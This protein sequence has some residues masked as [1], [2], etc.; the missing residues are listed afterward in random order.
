MVKYTKPPL[1]INQQIDLLISRGMEISDRQTAEKYLSHI[2][3]YRLRAYW[4]PFEE[5]SGNEAHQFRPGTKFEHALSLYIFDRKFRLL[6]LEAIERVEVSLRTRFS[7]I[8]SLKYGCHAYLKPEYFRKKEKHEELLGSLSEEIERSRETFI[9]HYKSKYTD[10]PMPPIWATCEVMSLGQL[11]IWFE[12]LKKR[13]DRK[14]IAEIY[15]LDEKVICSFMHHLSH[16]RNLAAHHSRLW[17]RQMTIT[18]IIPSNPQDVSRYFN[19]D[20]DRKIYNT[21]AMLVY[22]LN[23]ISPG[24]TWP[25]RLKQLIME[26]EIIDTSDMGFPSDWKEFELWKNKV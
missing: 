21:L 2:N 12:Q 18:M 23:I 10:P 16:V 1:S 19:S 4:L 26:Q 14:A 15:M 17:N 25:I 3:Y 13:Q 5:T 20:S 7:Y 11:S 9:K 8:L 24:T 6:V 22:V